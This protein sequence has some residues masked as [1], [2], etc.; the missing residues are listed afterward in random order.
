[1]IIM[2][3]RQELLYRQDDNEFSDEIFTCMQIYVS[4]F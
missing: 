2:Y 4:L 1:M 3:L